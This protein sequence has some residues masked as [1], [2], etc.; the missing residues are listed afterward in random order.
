MLALAYAPVIGSLVAGTLRG[1]T[2]NEV[3]ALGAAAAAAD[4]SDPIATM[5]ISPTPAAQIRRMC[6][7]IRAPP[8]S[9][10]PYGRKDSHNTTD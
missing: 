8:R 7:I 3:A 5:M 4:P 2:E 6:E 10:Q 1:S 9:N